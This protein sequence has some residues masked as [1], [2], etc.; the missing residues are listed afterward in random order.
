M[1]FDDLQILIPSRSRARSQKTIWN[2]SENLW[3]NL[4]IVVP[5]EQ[6]E[7]YRTAIPKDIGVMPCDGIGNCA[8]RHF[9]L[10]TK[11][12]GKLITFDDDLTFYRRIADGT[13][14]ERIFGK[15]TE[16]M[17]E[18]ILAYLDDYV[19]VGLVDKFMSQHTPRRHK[20]CARFN[21]VYGYNRD[22]LPVPWPE[23]RV[24]HEEEHDFHLQLLTRGHKTAV[25]TEYS[26][27]QRT[28]APG[29]C[30]DWRKTEIFKEAYNQMAQ[31]WPGIVS[32]GGK[33]TDFMPY[34][35]RYNWERAKQ[36]GGIT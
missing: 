24:P 1:M 3:P 23:F 22:T 30:A 31:L 36:Q 25:I 4:S 29:G 10:H 13:K 7:D 9:M 12:T 15:D 34:R 21:E 14:F 6:Y 8:T 19:F 28:W 27:G 5:S 26:K 20:E 17:V 35:I 32:F 33:P 18:V 11:E 2:I 16:T